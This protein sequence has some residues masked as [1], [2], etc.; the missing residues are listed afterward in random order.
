VQ[1][2]LFPASFH[3]NAAGQERLAEVIKTEVG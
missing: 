2:K 3:P 1:E